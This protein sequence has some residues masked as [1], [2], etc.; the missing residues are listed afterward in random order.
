MPKFV[1]KCEETAPE[2]HVSIRVK[3]QGQGIF[4]EICF[5]PTEKGTFVPSNLLKYDWIML[6]HAFPINLWLKFYYIAPTLCVY[7]GGEGLGRGS[8]G[9]VTKYRLVL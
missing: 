7:G 4:E 6:Q 2:V 9:E 5:S 3:C 1:T 8:T